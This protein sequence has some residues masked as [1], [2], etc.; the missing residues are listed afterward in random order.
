[1]AN[2]RL[3][4]AADDKAL[5][6]ALLTPH[7]ERH[8]G[9]DPMES[10]AAVATRLS[11]TE[12]ACRSRLHK[13]KRAAGKRGVWTKQGLWTPAEDDA[14]RARMWASAWGES[15]GWQ[16]V[17]EDLGRTAGACKTRAVRLRNE[18]RGRGSAT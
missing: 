10:L 8:A 1:M 17:A 18:S 7:D 13:L 12:S 9:G 14:I 16:E 5:L 6:A 11:R 15:P 4:S 3:W 2:G